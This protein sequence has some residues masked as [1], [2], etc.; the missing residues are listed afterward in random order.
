[1][2]G[3]VAEYVMEQTVAKILYH[4]GFEGTLIIISLLTIDFQPFAFDV[5][6]NIAIEYMQDLGRTLTMYQNNT[7]QRKKFTEEVGILSLTTHLQQGIILHML[8]LNG[9]HNLE[10]LEMYIKDDIERYGTKLED[11]HRRLKRFLTELL[12][13]KLP[14]I[15]LTR[16]AAPRTTRRRGRHT[17]L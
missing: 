6:T 5:V 15:K 1:M 13:T 14:T 7:D 11:C 8:D 12:V 10:Q 2:T 16:N 17:S 4:S 3:E 9:V